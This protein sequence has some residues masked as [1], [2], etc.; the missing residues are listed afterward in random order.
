LAIFY[1]IAALTR[2]VPDAY[3]K[4][5]GAGPS[6]R[7]DDLGSLWVDLMVSSNLSDP[8]CTSESGNR[9]DINGRSKGGE[10][11]GKSQSQTVFSLENAR[12]ASGVEP[13][14]DDNT[15]GDD[16]ANRHTEAADI[17]AIVRTANECGNVEHANPTVPTAPG[18]TAGTT[19]GNVPSSGGAQISAPAAV[20]ISADT[21]VA[22]HLA[23]SEQELLSVQ[24]QV[25]QARVAAKERALADKRRLVQRI[26]DEI[27]GLLA[28][29]ERLKT[30]A[31]RLKAA[32]SREEIALQHSKET[33]NLLLELV[34]TPETS[35]PLEI[36][37]NEDH[38][39]AVSRS[40]I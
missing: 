22:A 2:L 3:V 15:A 4:Q 16:E 31:Q 32:N 17:R 10:M 5:T 30:E 13:S 9:S 18:A 14:E 11:S 39:E 37:T 29:V 38:S 21:L 28:Q 6:A 12:R 23:L 1:P 33:M 35:L 36:S 19:S 34:T 27:Q 25:V 20:D 26:E 8:G 7:D 40:F 24:R